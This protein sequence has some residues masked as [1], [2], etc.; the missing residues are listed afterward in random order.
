MSANSVHDG[1]ASSSIALAHGTHRVDS[2][3]S[4]GQYPVAGGH[5]SPA[6]VPPSTIIAN[7]SGRTGT[8]SPAPTSLTSPTQPREAMLHAPFA[9]HVHAT[10]GDAAH[11]SDHGLSPSSNALPRIFPVDGDDREMTQSELP[12]LITDPVLIGRRNNP[13]RSYHIPA[14]LVRQDTTQSSLTSRSS[15]SSQ[16]SDGGTVSSYGSYTPMTPVEESRGQRSLPAPQS[17]PINA[18]FGGDAADCIQIQPL[19]PHTPTSLPSCTR[20]PTL[21][22]QYQPPSQS[23][24]TIFFPLE[25][26]PYCRSRMHV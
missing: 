18:P 6:N 26:S 13:R 19:Q 5:P 22:T 8:L 24:G 3:R 25:L 21:Q 20:L 12:P 23:P 10:F 7:S 2:V 15:L 17:M 1:S 4:I 14:P 11:E 9:A 16:I